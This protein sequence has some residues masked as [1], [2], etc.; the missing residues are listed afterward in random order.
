MGVSK[1]LE[2]L[3]GNNKQGEEESGVTNTAQTCLTY[4]LHSTRRVMI[5]DTRHQ[6]ENKNR[7][8]DHGV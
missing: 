4:S 6:M 7:I 3:S 2:A 8:D 1:G 5:V